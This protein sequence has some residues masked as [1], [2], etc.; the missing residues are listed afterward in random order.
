M[1]QRSLRRQRARGRDSGQK[2]Q[3]R[4]KNSSGLA[5]TLVALT[6]IGLLGGCGSK[7]SSTFSKTESKIGDTTDSTN[8][9]QNVNPPFNFPAKG[10]K[11]KGSPVTTKFHPDLPESKNAPDDKTQ[12]P[13]T[14]VI[15]PPWMTRTGARQAAALKEAKYY[16]DYQPQKD[17]KADALQAA[18]QRF[19]F[20]VEVFGDRPPQKVATG[21]GIDRAGEL[22][23]AALALQLDAIGFQVSIDLSN[24]LEELRER[25]GERFKLAGKSLAK[26]F[27]IGGEVS[28][29]ARLDRLENRFTAVVDLEVLVQLKMAGN[30]AKKIYERRFQ[31]RATQP[32]VNLGN[33]TGEARGLALR[34]LNAWV[35]DLLAD[36]SFTHAILDAL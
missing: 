28:F 32:D 26:R 18:R 20:E 14:K 12:P 8:E 5:K 15:N 16:V 25:L 34:A 7:Q 35:R 36:S 29:I 30:A 24:A 21:F 1:G 17:V 13:T 2:S 3:R 6:I 27:I 23:A 11:D 4:P 31:Q 10:Q 19:E 33:W 22:V 9:N